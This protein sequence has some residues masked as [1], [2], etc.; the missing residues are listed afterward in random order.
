MINKLII[1]TENESLQMIVASKNEQEAELQSMSEMKE[2]RI[3]VL[4]SIQERKS[5]VLCG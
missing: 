5:C 3:K 1:T 4:E 2:E